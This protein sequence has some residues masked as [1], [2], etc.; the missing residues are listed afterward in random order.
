LGYLGVLVHSI[1]SGTDSSLTSVLF[2]YAGTFLTTVFLMTYW[3]FLS[4]QKNREKTARQ[5]QVVQP[6]ASL[7]Q[8]KFRY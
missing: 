8:Q 7:T 3:I 1:L 5:K 6:A 2:L 4:V